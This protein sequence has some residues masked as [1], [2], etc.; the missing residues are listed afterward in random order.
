MGNGMFIITTVRAGIPDI[1]GTENGI[2]L[3]TNAK[4]VDVF[5]VI[6]GKPNIEV[7][8]VCKR[9]RKKIETS[10][11]QDNYLS[12]MR[13]TFSEIRLKT[14]YFAKNKYVE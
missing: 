13:L 5:D 4:A 3:K 10:F 8:Q 12:S 7:L 2:V 11:K 9:N 1:V 14:T 6:R